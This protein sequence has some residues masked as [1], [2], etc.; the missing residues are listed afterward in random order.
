MADAFQAAQA[1]ASASK[2][3]GDGIQITLPNIPL[4]TPAAAQ[5]AI[6][7]LAMQ[8]LR[9]ALHELAGRV[10]DKAAKYSDTGHLAQSF[11]A[12]PASPT[13]G[14][15]LIGGSVHTGLHGRVFSSLPYA[16]VI[17]QGRTAGRPISREGID[18][19]GLWA[20]RKLGMSEGEA[21][22][23]KFAIASAI[24][25]HGIEAKFFVEQGVAAARPRIET[26]FRVLADVVRQELMGGG[27]A[28]K[29]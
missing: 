28:A 9:L 6:N 27:P 5:Q 14:I 1:L 23:A 7:H 10:S 2:R 11:G 13:G 22:H 3:S 12:D 20:V 15:E 24:I 17:D 29:G 16:I 18:A 4:F 8:T 19:I 21:E 26:L 25:A